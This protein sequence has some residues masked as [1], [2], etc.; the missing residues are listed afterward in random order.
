MPPRAST[1][2][3]SVSSSASAGNP[4]CHATGPAA[5]WTSPA[6]TTPSPPRARRP[7]ST[8]N[9]SG[10]GTGGRSVAPIPSRE[11]DDPQPRLELLP[12]VGHIVD[13]TELRKNVHL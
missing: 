4:Y 10:S 9:V 11:L 6:K 12:P 5:V 2:T 13:S 3:S 7:S 1:S 8:Q